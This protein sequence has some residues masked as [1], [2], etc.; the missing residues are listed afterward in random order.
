MPGSFFY[1]MKALK[2]VHKYYLYFKKYEFFL[3]ILAACRCFLIPGYVLRIFIN[4]T[5]NAA[6]ICC[7]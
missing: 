2:K 6:V 1:L 4:Q 7:K 3:H 5:L